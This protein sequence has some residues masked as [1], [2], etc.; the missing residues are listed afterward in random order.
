MLLLLL[1]LLLLL[2]PSSLRWKREIDEAYIVI[3]VNI[4]IGQTRAV[5]FAVAVVVVV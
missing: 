5:I 3:V 1:L 4:V 2:F